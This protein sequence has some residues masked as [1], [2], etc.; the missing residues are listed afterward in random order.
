M[1]IRD[2]ESKFGAAEF[3]YSSNFLLN[4][5][6]E[7]TTSIKPL[8][9]QSCQPNKSIK[10]LTFKMFFEEDPH[11]SGL[12]DECYVEIEKFDGKAELLKFEDITPESLYWAGVLFKDVAR[13]FGVTDKSVVERN[14]EEHGG[15]K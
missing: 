13:H 14:E 5:R 10:R 15:G 11:S 6:A 12:V 3:N 2:I 4:K 7:A 1:R 9:S 8:Q